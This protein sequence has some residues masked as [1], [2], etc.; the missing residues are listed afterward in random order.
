MIRT[1]TE[2]DV[3]AIVAVINEAF[4]VE[5]EFRRG[6]RT[7]AAEIGALLARDTVLVTEQ[8]GRIVA[9]IHVRVSGTAGYF[10]MLAV[11]REA[12]GSG[13]GRALLDAAESHCRRAGCMKMTLSTG[14]D[15][16]ELIP[17]YERLGYRVTSVEPSASSAFSRQIRVVHM[18]KPL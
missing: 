5:R 2:A 8:E 10:G 12:Q 6:D 15:R 7:S 11:A 13:I 1:A 16:K 14:E 18:E 3:P 4:E 17:W 9:A